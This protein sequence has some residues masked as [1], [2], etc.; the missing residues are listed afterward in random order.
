MEMDDH[1]TCENPM[2]IAPELERVY[3]RLVGARQR[4]ELIADDAERLR[5]HLVGPEPE[6]RC[7]D[8]GPAQDNLVSRMDD[9]VSA[10]NDELRRIEDAHN[11]IN[12]ERGQGKVAVNRMYRNI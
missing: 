5:N 2:Q 12:R 9:I 1:G 8:P 4:A 6:D 3:G 7:E 10:L 11:D